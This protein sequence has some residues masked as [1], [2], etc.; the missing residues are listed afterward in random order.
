MCVLVNDMMSEKLEICHNLQNFL[1]L[2][3]KS[4]NIIITKY[5]K[6]LGRK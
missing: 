6:F 3:L 1:G 4:F 2:K 5:L